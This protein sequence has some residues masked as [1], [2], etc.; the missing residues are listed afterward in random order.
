MKPLDRHILSE[1]YEMKSTRSFQNACTCGHG[2]ILLTED[3]MHMYDTQY[4]TIVEIQ[5]N[6]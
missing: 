6:I 5:S 4:E 2:L 1:E 3:K